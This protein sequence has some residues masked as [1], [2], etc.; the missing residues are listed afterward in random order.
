MKIGLNYF[1]LILTYEFVRR[2]AYSSWYGP[3]GHN[4][5][6]L[7]SFARSAGLVSQAK[8]VRHGPIGPKSFVTRFTHNKCRPHSLS[9]DNEFRLECD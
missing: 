7:T 5:F 9:K 6:L 1:F 8:L 4:H 3:I 2:G